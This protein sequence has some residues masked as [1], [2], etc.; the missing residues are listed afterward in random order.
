MK[1]SFPPGDMCFFGGGKFNLVY[2]LECDTTVDSQLFSVTKKQMCDYEFKF[3]TKMACQTNFEKSSSFSSKGIL[4]A[5]I[6]LFSVYC[7]GFFLKN[8]RENPEDGVM[9]ALPH[10]EFWSNFIENANYGLRII[11]R[12]AKNKLKVNDATSGYT[13]Y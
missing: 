10:R 4:F 5:L 9:K 6:A 2:I 3:K 7:L 11:L 13:N 8:Y 12:F 1:L